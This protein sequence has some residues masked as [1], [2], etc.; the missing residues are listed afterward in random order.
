MTTPD[1]IHRIAARFGKPLALLAALHVVGTFGYRVLGGPQYSLLDC[2]YMT[3]ITIATIGYA[4][5]VDLSANPAGRLFTMALGFTGIAM[6]W[7]LFS[8]LT[9]FI[10]EGE[11]DIAL[12]RRR[13]QKSIDRLFGHYIICGIGR[14]GANV[15]HELAI[16]ARPHVIIDV[17]QHNIDAYRERHDEVLWLHGDAAED[18]LLQRA[19]IGRAAGLFAITGDDAKNLVIT[20]SAK[21]LNPAVRVVARCHDVGYIDKIRLVGA[22]AIV[23][24]DFT[25]GMR[26]ASSMVRPHV[27]NFLDEMLRSEQAL[28]VEELRV[29]E[30]YG[31]NALGTIE[32]RSD[33][34]LIIALRRGDAWRFNPPADYLVRGG[35]VL[36]F[37]ATPQGRRRLEEQLAT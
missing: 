30:R 16:T 36:V 19:G 9:A 26:I 4:E 27:V 20:L 17:S 10:V 24:P 37:M 25:G 29:P 32:P 18:E 11:I 3:F 5:V 35:D 8:S 13:M 28:R 2:L 6:T 22:D 21:K 15:G 33:D 14:V 12:R 23:S 31:E 34:Y 1:I 7:Y